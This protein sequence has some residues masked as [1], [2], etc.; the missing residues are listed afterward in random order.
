MSHAGHGLRDAALQDRARQNPADSYPPPAGDSGI[1]PSN[2]AVAA[3]EV[4]CAALAASTH[5]SKRP[6]LGETPCEG[7]MDG[8]Y[9]PSSTVLRISA[10]FSPLTMNSTHAASFK[11]G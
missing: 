4:R 1:V 3:L 11:T 7:H 9:G 10:F 5:H 8:S 6:F 2:P